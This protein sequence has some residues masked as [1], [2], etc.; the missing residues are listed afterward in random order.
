MRA[1]IPFRAGGGFINRSM[2]AAKFSGDPAD[3][4]V[5]GNSHQTDGVLGT[6]RAYRERH[7]NPELTTA[8]AINGSILGTFASRLS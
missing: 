3:Q 1:D 4:R 2:T 7:E 5:A 6:L 8:I